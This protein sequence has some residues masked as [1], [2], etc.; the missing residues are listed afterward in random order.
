MTAVVDTSVVA[1]FLL[2]ADVLARPGVRPTGVRELRDA[3]DI[4]L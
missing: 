3:G 2:G 1:Y 4:V